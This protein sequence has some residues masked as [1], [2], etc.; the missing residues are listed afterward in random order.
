MSRDSRV[1]AQTEQARAAWLMA[2]DLSAGAVG[3]DVREVLQTRGVRGKGGTAP[4]TRAR[5][6]ACYLAL[7][8]SNADPSRLAEAARI[9]RT[10]LRRHAEWVEDRRDDPQ[11]PEFEALVAGMEAAI[12]GA[13]LRICAAKIGEDP[14]LPEAA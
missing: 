13:A 9:D 10:T 2:C 3:C 6:L 8:V 4:V 12:F 11:H 5:K 1:K 14:V 7:V